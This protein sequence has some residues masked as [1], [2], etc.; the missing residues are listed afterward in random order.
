MSL[1]TLLVALSFAVV[2]A[3]TNAQ[4]QSLGREFT[5]V[6][7]PAMSWT[8]RDPELAA[9]PGATLH[10]G[11]Y[12]GGL[13]AIEIPD[14]WNGD[15]VLYAHGLVDPGAANG[16]TLRVGP[17]GLRTHWIRNGFAWAASSYRC[18]GHV[19]GVGLLDTMALP[20]LFGRLNA[21]RMPERVYL[22]G[23]SL[24]GRI[25]VLGLREF[26]SVLAGGLAMCPMGP[27]T[28]DLRTAI[29]AAAELLTG[30]RPTPATLQKDLARMAEILGRAPAYT[31]VGSQLASAQIELTGG[32]RPFALEGLESRFIENIRVGLTSTPDE[33]I[34]AATNFGITYSV[35]GGLGVTSN[36]LNVRVPRKAA[37][38]SLRSS[39]GP[40]GELRP[41]DGDLTRPLLTIHG[42]GDLQ[43]PV[44]QEQAMKRAVMAAG[45]G[46][47]LVQRLMRI[48]GHCQFSEAE[49][50]QAFDDMV[51]WV[52]N[53]VQPEGDDVLGDL[54]NAGLKFTNPLRPGDP[55]TQ[56]VIAR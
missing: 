27:E 21:G 50:I 2:P 5:P 12:D 4:S 26:P 52:R 47:L 48:P 22:A 37:D 6:P 53:G 20:E 54:T 17:P 3:L 35:A 42:T 24:G 1:R 31:Q 43:V 56:G 30:V 49:E 9:L 51:N 7:C 19:Y 29:A 46:E 41:F 15:L 23:H 8:Y 16:T 38:L 40:Y 33:P 25:T 34:R 32:L 45:K 11:R 55:G 39:A 44:S 10:T 28:W 36:D 14:N 18:N 13:Y